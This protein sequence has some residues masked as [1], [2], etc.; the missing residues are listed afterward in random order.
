MPKK[1]D[2]RASFWLQMRE[3]ERNIIG[4][5][6]EHVTSIRQA[7]LLLGVSPH[8][9]ARRCRMLNV[10]SPG[11]ILP[12][13]PPPLVEEKPAAKPKKTAKAKQAAKRARTAPAVPPTS[14]PTPTPAIPSGPPQL[15]V[16]RP[17]LPT[18][19]E[20]ASEGENEDENEDEFDDDDEDG[21][22]EGDDED[23]EDDEDE[24]EDEDEDDPGTAAILHKPRPDDDTDA[25]N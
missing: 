6:L 19:P 15:R 18:A 23:E 21:D 20:A 24:D 22:F 8:F 16:V 2:E 10:T 4:F 12:P 11:I 17:T 7:A 3:A 13:P 1:K 9:L 14:A 25:A 5:T